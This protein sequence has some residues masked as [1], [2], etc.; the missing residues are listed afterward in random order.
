MDRRTVYFGSSIMSLVLRPNRIVVLAQLG[1][2]A[3]CIAVCAAV[4]VW[5]PRPSAGL[6]PK[7]VFIAAFTAPAFVFAAT[8]YV[9]RLAR[10]APCLI[11]DADG[12]F[13]DSPDKAGFLPWSAVERVELGVGKHG[14]FDQK[15]PFIVVFAKDAAMLRFVTNPFC[16]N[17][18]FTNR[19]QF[20]TPLAIP[21][22]FIDAP[23]EEVVA[24]M[25]AY[26]SASRA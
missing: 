7:P 18:R 1:L 8:L 5:W 14:F 11:V 22:Q 19:K 6:I 25:N 15:T 10:R 16:Q 26:L 9:L 24:K 4:I 3:A 13:D 21:A 23:T 12:F 2:A 17:A 20:G